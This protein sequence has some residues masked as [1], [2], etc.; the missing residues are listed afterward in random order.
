M[1][2]QGVRDRLRSPGGQKLLKYS[3]ASVVSVIVSVVLLVIFDGLIGWPAAVSSTLATAIAT[4]P[5]YELNRKWAWGKSGKSHLWKEVV[6]FWALAFLGWGLSTFCVDLME[7]YA[8]HHH[9]AHLLKTGLVT[10]VYVGAFGI[11]WVGKFIIFNR[12]LFVHHHVEDAAPPVA[13]V[14]RSGRDQ[15]EA[16]D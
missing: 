15:A 13:P 6:P 14:W 1:S 16:F 11:L 2:V 5:S 4:V 3:A 7:S 12:V 8:K 10:V 9:I